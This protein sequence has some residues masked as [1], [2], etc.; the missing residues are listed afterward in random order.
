MESA[1]M[2]PTAPAKNAKA[3]TSGIAESPTQYA[4]SGADTEA[5]YSPADASNC[6]GMGRHGRGGV[7][8][9]LRGHLG[10]AVGAGPLV[11]VGDHHLLEHVTHGLVEQ[12]HQVVLDSQFRYPTTV[13]GAALGTCRVMQIIHDQDAGPIRDGCL[14]A[15]DIKGEVPVSKH[16]CIRHGDSTMKFYLRFIDR[17]SRIRIEN[18]V[19]RVHQREQKFRNDRFTPRLDRHIGRCKGPSCPSPAGNHPEIHFL[20]TKTLQVLGTELPV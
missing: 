8:A 17:E 14:E 20:H 7:D 5:G 6:A 15:V 12:H 16:C 2:K 10:D 18:L 13:F 9:A 19:T 4:A 1:P 3:I 11:G